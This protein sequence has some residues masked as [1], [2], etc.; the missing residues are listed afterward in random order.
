MYTKQTYAHDNTGK[1]V[2]YFGKKVPF[3]VYEGKY[4]DDVIMRQGNVKKRGR[5]RGEI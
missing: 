3:P 4:I 1:R 2:Q 5:E